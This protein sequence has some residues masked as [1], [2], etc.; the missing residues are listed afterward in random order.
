VG[1]AGTVLYS[2]GLVGV[3]WL[4]FPDALVI[5]QGLSGRFYRIEGTSELSANDDWVWQTEVYVPSN[6]P[7]VNP[8]F[9]PGRS[10]GTQQFFR[11]VLIP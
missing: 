9:L 7:P 4:S 1:D 3:R 6:G 8:V 10:S 5:L 11:A 2:D